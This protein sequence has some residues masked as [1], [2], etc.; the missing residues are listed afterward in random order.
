MVDTTVD[1]QNVNVQLPSGGDF[2]FIDSIK[3]I[4]DG[5]VD[6]FRNA[7]EYALTGLFM[8]FLLAM[9]VGLLWRMA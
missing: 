8:G 7:D 6:S 4:I 3:G 5:I 1:V 2:T 9:M